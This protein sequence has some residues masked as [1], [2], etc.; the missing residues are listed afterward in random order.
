MDT[1]AAFQLPRH[2]LHRG[3][4]DIFEREDLETGVQVACLDA[5]HVEE[6]RDQPVE[7]LG[8]A[9]D[10]RRTL[11]TCVVIHHEARVH[12]AAGSGPDRRERR[13]QVVRDGVEQR[14]LGRL[15]PP[16]DLGAGG[17]PPPGGRAPA[18]G[19]SGRPPRRAPAPGRDRAARRCG[20]ARPRSSRA[21]SRRRRSEPGTTSPRDRAPL[22]TSDAGRGP[23]PRRWRHPRRVAAAPRTTPGRRV[24][25]PGRCPPRRAPR[26][27]PAPAR[28]RCALRRSPAAGSPRAP[29]GRHGQASWS[30]AGGRPGTG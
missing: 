23:G 22:P 29:P 15:A 9:V 17:L 25:R 28:P 11:S 20:L 19:R 14:G 10:R 8:L 18:P 27:P 26:R 5:T 16:G 3:P 6:V 12:E 1:R 21:G 13:A 30:R 2:A 24:G 4:H 7:A